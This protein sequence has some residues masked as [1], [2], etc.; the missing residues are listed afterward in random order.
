MLKQGKILMS[1][2]RGLWSPLEQGRHRGSIVLEICQ[3]MPMFPD[4]TLIIIVYPHH[5]RRREP[6]RQHTVADTPHP[7]WS[8]DCSDEPFPWNPVVRCFVPPTS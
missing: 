6:T 3:C 8:D 4:A 5:E 2:L 7:Y 1:V